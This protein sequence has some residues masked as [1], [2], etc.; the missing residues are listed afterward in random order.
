MA[1][2]LLWRWEHFGASPEPAGDDPVQGQK[3]LFFSASESWGGE[4]LLTLEEKVFSTPLEKKSFF[5]AL[6]EPFFCPPPFSLGGGW[7]PPPFSLPRPAPRVPLRRAVPP[8][9]APAAAAALTPP[10]PAPATAPPRSPAE[11]VSVPLPETLPPAT[12]FQLP[13]NASGEKHPP[14]SEREHGPAATPRPPPA[15]P[16]PPLPAPV[17]LIPEPRPEAAA[18]SL[19]AVPALSANPIPVQDDAE[20]AAVAPPAVPA[21]PPPLMP[22]A[23]DAEVSATEPAPPA[24]SDHSE[25]TA[26]AG[27]VVSA[28]RLSLHG[29]FFFS[30]F[31]ELLSGPKGLSEMSKRNIFSPWTLS[32][33]SQLFGLE[34]MDILCMDFCIFL[35]CKIV[36][37]I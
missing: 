24:S 1:E 28:T 23:V 25:A 21:V 30:T 4:A 26:A 16:P 22:R 12:S 11:F 3:L 34:T 8:P 29:Q 19:P 13:G 5:Y 17:Q 18:V 33:E 7:A 27:T 35:Y 2:L 6:V 37:V 36:L 14:V 9:P 10:G 31:C 20:A 15:V 32:P